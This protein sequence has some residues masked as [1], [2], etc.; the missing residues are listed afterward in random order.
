MI[1]TKPRSKIAK[2]TKAPVTKKKYVVDGTKVN[3]KENTSKLYNVNDYEYLSLLKYFNQLS[4]RD[5]DDEIDYDLSASLV[6]LSIRDYDDELNEIST[7]LK[8]LLI[9]DGDDEI[10][11]LCIS[12][13]SLSTDCSGEEEDSSSTTPLPPSS[14]AT[15]IT[16]TVEEG[17]ATLVELVGGLNRSGLEI[18]VY[19]SSSRQEENINQRLEEA[20][21]LVDS[22]ESFVV[23]L[24]SYIQNN[25][26]VQEWY[27]YLK[28]ECGKWET[29]VEK[30]NDCAIRAIRDGNLNTVLSGPLYQ[31]GI[32]QVQKYYY[33]LCLVYFYYNTENSRL[34]NNYY[35]DLS[36]FLDQNDNSVFEIE[37]LESLVVPI[38]L[39]EQKR[40]VRSGL[41]RCYSDLGPLVEMYQASQDSILKKQ[42]LVSKMK[43]TGLHAVIQEYSELCMKAKYWKFIKLVADSLPN[44][45]RSQTRSEEDHQWFQE[46]DRFIE[47]LVAGIHEFNS[48][49]GGM[50]RKRMNEVV[51]RSRMIY[52]VSKVE[53]HQETYQNAVEEYIQYFNDGEFNG[54]STALGYFHLL[55]ESHQSILD[56]VVEAE[57]HPNSIQYLIDLNLPDFE[58]EFQEA[59]EWLSS[60]FGSPS[61]EMT[62]D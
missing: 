41:L 25:V 4:I 5:F 37:T 14:P 58:S 50:I 13:Q 34:V 36:F 24:K 28:M 2:K 17:P 55:R 8:S 48:E 57:H 18:Q 56:L 32:D 38:E 31:C 20:N 3:G 39:V 60:N 33:D 52:L 16:I 59:L 10:D 35:R 29:L 40:H 47:D 21:G 1:T 46:L 7:S 53:I 62:V 43:E 45:L 6:S 12:F 51:L 26:L 49:I 44:S 42:V 23:S 11:G 30:F 19:P 61:D 15:T 22:I 27:D 9:K 54:D